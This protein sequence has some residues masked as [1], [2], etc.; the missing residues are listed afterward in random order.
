M[1]EHMFTR[2]TSVQSLHATQEQWNSVQEL[3][4]SFF[5]SERVLKGFVLFLIFNCCTCVNFSVLISVSVSYMHHSL[6][7]TQ[8]PKIL[9]LGHSFVR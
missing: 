5:P 7:M 9:I 3:C 8:P 2:L 1:K 4:I 6:R